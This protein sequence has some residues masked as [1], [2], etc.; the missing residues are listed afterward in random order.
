VQQLYVHNGATESITGQ[1]TIDKAAM[2]HSGTCRAC[3]TS[4]MLERA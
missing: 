1:I 4:L 2:Y 3:I